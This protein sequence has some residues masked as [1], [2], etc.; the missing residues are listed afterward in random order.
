MK[1]NNCKKHKGTEIWIGDGGM[2]G[3]VHGA[4]SN[5]CKCCTLKAQIRHI[6]KISKN[7]EKL[8]K[9]LAEVKCK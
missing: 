4:Y 1:C 2:M 9:E 3:Y 5:W 8:A 7:L 6:K